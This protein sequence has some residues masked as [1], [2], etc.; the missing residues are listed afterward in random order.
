MAFKFVLIFLLL[1]IEP[2][3]VSTIALRNTNTNA[4]KQIGPRPW[5]PGL[6]DPHSFFSNRP[7]H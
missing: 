7:E 6:R 2:D 4:Q 3:F 1:N 5:A